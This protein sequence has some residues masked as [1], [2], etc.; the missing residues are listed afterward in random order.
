MFK[1][2]LLIKTSD[3]LYICYDEEDTGWYLSLSKK[4]V[5]KF[6]SFSDFEATYNKLSSNVLYGYTEFYSELLYT[7]V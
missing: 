6:D 3:N 1:K 7:L 4:D 5:V 2:Q